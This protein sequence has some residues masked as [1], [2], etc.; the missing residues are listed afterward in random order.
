MKLEPSN[1]TSW[2]KRFPDRFSSDCTS[3]CARAL[4]LWPLFIVLV[5]VPIMNE[6]K[7]SVNEIELKPNREKTMHFSDINFRPDYSSHSGGTS[8]SQKHNG[9]R[10]KCW[11]TPVAWPESAFTLMA[12]ATD[13]IYLFS[14]NSFRRTVADRP[15]CDAGRTFVFRQPFI[16][17]SYRSIGDN[18]IQ[19]W[20]VEFPA[21]NR[22]HDTITAHIFMQ[23]RTIK[24]DVIKHF[25]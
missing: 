20:T 10:L 1:S 18:L 11:I 25:I 12:S 5:S 13:S 15:N 4:S 17:I 2:V 24:S 21:L 19:W 22:T 6:K 16:C 8:N 14:L 23:Q 7:K 3:K 9:V